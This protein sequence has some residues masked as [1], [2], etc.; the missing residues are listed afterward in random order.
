MVSFTNGYWMD[1]I[2][3]QFRGE[4]PINRQCYCGYCDFRRMDTCTCLHTL[5]IEINMHL[6]V[7]INIF[8]EDQ[9]LPSSQYLIQYPSDEVNID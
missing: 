6:N 9:I 4:S 5:L 1:S 7:L 2:R 3:P 8:T